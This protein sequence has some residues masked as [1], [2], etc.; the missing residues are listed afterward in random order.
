MQL[1][2]NALFSACR[3]R[4][5]TR[6]KLPLTVTPVL[7]EAGQPPG[8]PASI[9]LMRWAVVSVGFV[10]RDGYHAVEAFKVKSPTIA[11]FVR[12]SYSLNDPK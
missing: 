10:P 1:A 8:D 12:V 2:S 9:Q 5:S 7:A 6:L 4:L 11:F 3:G